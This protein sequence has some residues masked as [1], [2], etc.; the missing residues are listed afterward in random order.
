MLIR[1]SGLI[2]IWGI[3]FSNR[4]SILNIVP[5][6][7]ASCD[8]ISFC[9]TLLLDTSNDSSFNNKNFNVRDEGTDAL[10]NMCS[11]LLILQGNAI[12]FVEYVPREIPLHWQR[13]EM[14]KSREM[15]KVEYI[16]DF[17]ATVQDKILV[18]MIFC[19]TGFSFERIGRWLEKKEE[20]ACCCVQQVLHSS[21]NHSKVQC[22]PSSTLASLAKSTIHQCCQD[23]I[24][25]FVNPCWKQFYQ[26]GFV[27]RNMQISQDGEISLWE[28]A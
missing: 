23:A 24:E 25:R 10:N 20:Y 16:T 21:H 3:I 6:C 12:V 19:I 9:S 22:I 5:Q 8:A 26:H 13:T 14:L 27:S 17:S 15:L 2:E 4:T 1:F 18:G 7:W 11:G 28:L